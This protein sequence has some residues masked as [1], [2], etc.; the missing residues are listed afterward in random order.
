MIWIYQRGAENLHIATTF[1]NATNEYVITITGPQGITCERF[2][3]AAA[4]QVRMEALEGS[5]HIERWRR[6][7]DAVILPD[8]WKVGPAH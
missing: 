4:F 3:D 2:V 1:D 7:G 8:G 6:V 5:I